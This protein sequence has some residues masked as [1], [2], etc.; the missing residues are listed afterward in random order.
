MG[1]GCLKCANDKYRST[2]EDFTNKA[3]KL[4]GDKYD[5]SKVNYHNWQ[6]KVILVCKEHGEFKQMPNGHLSGAG[7]PKCS[8][9]V[10]KAENEIA[11]FLRLHAEVQQSNKTILGG[12]EID[13]LIPSKNLAIE[14]NGLYWHSDLYKKDDYHLNK[15]NLCNSKGLRLIQIFEDEWVSKKA[16]V[17]S[18]LLN[19]LH[20]GVDKIYARKCNIREISSVVTS[21][22]LEENHIQGK[23]G[24]KVRLG[25]YN[26]EELVA[27]MTFGEFRKNLGLKSKEG[28]YEL[29]RFCTKLNT[30]I[31]GGASKL[32]KYFEI[33]YKPITLIS[34]ADRRW[35][36]GSLYN[37]LGFTLKG[38][39]TPNYFYTK[40][41]VREGRFKYRKSELVRL[42]YDTSKSE[43]EIM[44]DLGYYRIY[45]SGT[46]KFVKE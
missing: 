22:F 1:K 28:S 31:I 8:G 41:R 45:D 9:Y 36:E 32:L 34:Y 16:I 33:N 24:A 42:G 4:H 37:T 26:K 14:F 19:L 30:S 27:L 11:D 25:L 20:L 7:C 43:R 17:K 13:I 6:T 2:K 35:S 3:V 40:G 44:N 21:R 18:R 10:S 15:L 5:Y 23:L 29:L 46:L 39:T 38:D 12:K